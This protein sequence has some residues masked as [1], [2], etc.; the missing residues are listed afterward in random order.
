M[1]DPCL[2]LQR[3]LGVNQFGHLCASSLPSVEGEDPL[4]VMTQRLQ[5][6]RKSLFALWAY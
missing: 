1:L 4:K 5:N 6:E 3:E 2:H